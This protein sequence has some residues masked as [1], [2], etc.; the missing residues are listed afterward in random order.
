MLSR[1]DP[2]ANKRKVAEHGL[3]FP[4]LL[5]RHWEIS[6]EYGMFATPIAYLIDEHGVIAADVATGPDAILALAWGKEVAMHERIRARLAALRQELETG[7]VEL[8][9]V[10]RRQ[11]YLRETLLR[12]SGAVQVLEE[13]LADGQPAGKNGVHPGEPHPVTGQ[14]S[15]ATVEG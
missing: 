8:Q 9:Q 11:A 13:L 15:T 1:A 10:E 3:T 14:A 6:R 2:E 5:Q 12:I 7:Q 4:V